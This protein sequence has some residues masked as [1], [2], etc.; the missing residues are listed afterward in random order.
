M[1]GIIEHGEEFTLYRSFNTLPGNRNLAIHCFLMQLERRI[2]RDGR[3]PK[4]IYYQVDGGS[5]NA[6][7]TVLAVCEM[8]IAMGLTERIEY[9]RLMV[10][11]THED[12]DGRFG[13]IWLNIQSKHVTTPQ[14]YKEILLDVFKGSDNRVAVIDLF[15]VP[16]YYRLLEPCID[17]KFSR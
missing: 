11:H 10:G 5:E 15:V 12:I 6:N 14:E 4:T 8:L 16:D 3:L 13:R 7:K 9:C 17:P 1:T 2:D